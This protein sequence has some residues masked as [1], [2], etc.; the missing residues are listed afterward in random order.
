[1]KLEAEA[2][3]PSLVIIL[4]GQAGNVADPWLT[5]YGSLP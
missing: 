2:S 4:S 1:M 5:P 3:P